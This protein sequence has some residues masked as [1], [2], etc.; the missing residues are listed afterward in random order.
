[1]ENENMSLDGVKRLRWIKF[2]PK[3]GFGP[4][5]CYDDTTAATNQCSS[6]SYFWTDSSS[7]RAATVCS[8][9]EDTCAEDKE[10][11]I[12]L[13][14]LLKPEYFGEAMSR[15]YSLEYNANL[16]DQCFW[17]IDEKIWIDMS[18]HTMW[19]AVDYFNSAEDFFKSLVDNDL[20]QGKW[21]GYDVDDKP[22]IGLVRLQNLISSFVSWWCR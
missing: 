21:H 3:A 18:D 22:S 5:T 13:R 12:V 7:G 8:S 4:T 19:L 1:M 2:K 6:S 9:G 15:I 16:G 17:K 11:V 14:R 10:Q 20:D